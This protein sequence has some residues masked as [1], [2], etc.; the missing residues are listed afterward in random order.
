MRGLIA[1]ALV[2]SLVVVGSAATAAQSPS[3]NQTL[4]GQRI[5]MSAHGLAITFPYDWTV[6]QLTS[7]GFEIGAQAEGLPAGMSI[8]LDAVG[9]LGGGTC[10]LEIDDPS[11]R[12]EPVLLATYAVAVERNLAQ[13]QDP[14]YDHVKRTRVGLPAGPAWRFDASNDD[15]SATLYIL[16]GQDGLY[17]VTCT[18]DDPPEDRWLS[19]V[20]TLKFLPDETTGSPPLS[21][22]LGGGRIERPAEGFAVTFPDDWMVEEVTPEN[23]HCFNDCDPE[24]RAIQTFVL[25]AD[26]PAGD[27]ACVVIDFT[28]QAAEP[29]AWTTLREA[30]EGRWAGW[31]AD[32]TL[33]GPEFAFRDLPSGP[34]GLL[35]ATDT[36]GAT[37]NAYV[38]T[39]SKAWFLLECWAADPPD[40]RWLSIAETFE[41]LAVEE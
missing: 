1:T 24:S 12:G 4:E 7:E 26:R 35:R 13:A 39:D 19:I 9:P 18:S 5:E 32:P 36:D 17:G 23:A 11:V 14:A 38:L 21:P 29:P 20:E 28:L 31:K 34:I 16:R 33:M 3:S 37:R 2:T 25:W 22:M 27:G 10:Y 30:T 6:R 41:F 15:A 8:V 40:D